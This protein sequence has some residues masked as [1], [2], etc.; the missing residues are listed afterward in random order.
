MKKN[1]PGLL[2]V[3]FRYS[4]TA[5][6]VCSP[7][8]NLTG[9][10][11]FF[12]RTVAIRRV[13]AGGN[14]LDP[15]GNDVATTKLGRTS[16]TSRWTS[17]VRGNQPTIEAFNGCF[18]AECLNGHW[19]LSLADARKKVEWR[20][21]YNEERPIGRSATNRRFC[22]KTTMAP[23]AATAIRAKSESS[24]THRGSAWTRIT[25]TQNPRYA[26]RRGSRT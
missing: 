21:Y 4:S 18:R 25:R 1:S 2:L 16:A 10:P 26:A 7:N 6:R 14:I 9:C 23:P 13:P 12:C 15:D 20:T 19:F 5:W 24:S 22:R 17:H 11:V 3:A 8:S